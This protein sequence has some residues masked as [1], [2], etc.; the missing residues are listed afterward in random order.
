[1]NPNG[2]AQ[3]SVPWRTFVNTNKQ[4]QTLGLQSASELYWRSDRR[5]SAK[6]VPTLTDRGSRVVSATNPPHSLISVF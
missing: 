6:L 5:L 4:E 1:M 2:V 3:E